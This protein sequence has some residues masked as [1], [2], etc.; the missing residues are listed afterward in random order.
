MIGAQPGAVPR[1]RSGDK[2][3]QLSAF[4]RGTLNAAKDTISAP[5]RS[6]SWG[7]DAQGNWSTV[8]TDL[9]PANRTYNR[10]NQITSGGVT[11]DADGNLTADGS[12]KTFV[13]DAWN[14]LK[15]VEQGMTVLAS[16]GYDAL[17]RR[18][19]EA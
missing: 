9:T 10:Q 13:Y 18:V 6:Q 14:R 19:V 1:Q 11:Y 7:Y 12:G 4:A 17:G 5:A 15:R 16:Y 8:T 2:L 3:D